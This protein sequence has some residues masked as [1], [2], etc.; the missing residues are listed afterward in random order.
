MLGVTGPHFELAL[1]PAIIC[2]DGIWNFAFRHFF[3][4]ITAMS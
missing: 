2:S 1:R 3:C 4:H